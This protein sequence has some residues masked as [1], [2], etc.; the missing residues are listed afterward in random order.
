MS[1]N[2]KFKLGVL[3]NF[4][5]PVKFIMPDGE[6]AKITF[7]VKHKTIED[8]QALYQ[9]ETADN[10]FITAIAEGWDLDEEFNDENVLFLVKHY[11]AAALSLTNSYIGAMLG[12]RVKN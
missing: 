6:E 4:K 11:P 8:V 1:K 7:T 10:E 12:Q 9:G 2:F 5:L 3:P